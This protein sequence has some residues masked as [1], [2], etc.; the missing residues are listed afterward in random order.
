MK[1]QNT[2]L[3][4]IGKLETSTLEMNSCAVAMSINAKSNFLKVEMEN[5]KSEKNYR[6]EYLYFGE[7]K[8]SGYF[9]FLNISGAQ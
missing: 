9:S 6:N 2:T 1:V 7:P 5:K 3:T 4:P 8:K